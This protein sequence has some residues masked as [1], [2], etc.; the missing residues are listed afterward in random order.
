[1]TRY[2]NLT[3]SPSSYAATLAVMLRFRYARRLSRREGAVLQAVARGSS[4]A[5]IAQALGTT[6]NGV[7]HILRAAC[8]KLGARNRNH[9]VAIALLT[10][11]IDP[12]TESAQPSAALV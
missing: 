11:V 12:P 8:R 3:M 2:P 5:A 4:S 10:G 6:Q 7:R 9:A 1:M